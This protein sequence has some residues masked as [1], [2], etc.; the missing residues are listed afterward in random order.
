MREEL[1]AH[2]APIFEE[3]ARKARRRAGRPRTGQAAIRRPEELSRQ[4]RDTVP[5][6]DRVR[7]GIKRM[8]LQPGESLLHLAGKQLLV[9][10]A[11]YG[12]AVLSALPLMI[13]RGRLSEVGVVLRIVLVTSLICTSFTFLFSLIPV[14]IGRALYGDA[15]ERSLPAV[16]IYALLSPSDLPRDGLSDLFGACR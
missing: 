7:S 9:V 8:G 10:L 15:S 3:E 14:R 12:V 4:L 11:M 5:W 1:L 13:A 2:L 6:W 16:A